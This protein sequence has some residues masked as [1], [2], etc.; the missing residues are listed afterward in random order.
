MKIPRH[1]AWTS[2]RKL[3]SFGGNGRTGGGPS[4]AAVAN[5][6]PEPPRPK[7]F[8]NSPFP[9]LL[10]PQGMTVPQF[11]WENIQTEN[12]NKIAFVSFRVRFSSQSITLYLV[13][14]IICK[15]TLV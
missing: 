6:P 2:L 5:P 9:D 7:S 12:L 14:I 1:F 3:S 8:V 4:A 13:S 10:I 11:L 15:L